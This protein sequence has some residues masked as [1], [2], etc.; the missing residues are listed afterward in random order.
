MPYQGINYFMLSMIAD[1]GGFASRYWITYKKAQELGGQVRKGETSAPAFFYKS[2]DAAI[3][4]DN[5]GDAG[6]DGT[7]RRFVLKS[8]SVFNADQIDGLPERFHE[9]VPPRDNR[10]DSESQIANVL[11]H[12][13]AIVHHGG[14]QA[15]YRPSTDSITMPTLAQFHSYGAYA[16][17]LLHELVHWTSAPS[18]LNRQLGA[19]FG[20]QAYAAEELI[21]ELGSAHLCAELGIEGE[22]I[23][24]HAAYI[25]S[26]IKV[27]KNDPRAILTAAAQA[28]AAARHILP[29]LYGHQDQE[30]DEEAQAA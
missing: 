5:A 7:Q 22:H 18:R 9:A 24:N 28:D 4:D 29:D 27:L 26:W 15:F 25:A 8:Y 19:R 13:G 2:Y 11:A 6:D 1:N 21:A 23:D 30:P 3:G 10:S 14:D 17:T 20:D 12:T 16:A